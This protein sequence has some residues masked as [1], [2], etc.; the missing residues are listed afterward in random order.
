MNAPTPT[1]RTDAAGETVP[2]RECSQ[3]LKNDSIIFHCGPHGREIMRL[4]ADGM[5][6]KGQRIDD[7]GEA[8]R[9]FLQVMGAMGAITEDAK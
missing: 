1:P 4:D 2:L 5:S 9:A 7:A 3:Q 6:Y 8:H